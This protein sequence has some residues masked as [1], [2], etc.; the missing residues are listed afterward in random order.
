MMSTPLKHFLNFLILLKWI[1]PI[2][3]ELLKYLKGVE[4][5]Y[6]KSVPEFSSEISSSRLFSKINL[7]R[8]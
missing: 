6:L 3:I 8:L 5:S 1:F 2:D 7:L 4:G